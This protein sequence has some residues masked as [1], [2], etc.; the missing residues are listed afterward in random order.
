MLETKAMVKRRV[1][2]TKIKELYLLYKINGG[3]KREVSAA[4][5]AKECKTSITTVK[6]VTKPMEEE[7]C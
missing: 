4:K 2:D 5:I 7:K 6:R 1:R 3:S